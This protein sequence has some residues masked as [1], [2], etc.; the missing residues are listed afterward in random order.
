MAAQPKQGH[1][2]TPS[3]HPVINMSWSSQS[4]SLRC[5]YTTF[6]DTIAP[7]LSIVE[8]NPATEQISKKCQPQLSD[9]P[10]TPTAARFIPKPYTNDMFV[11]SG[12]KLRMFQIKGNDVI[13]MGPL[14]DPRY[15]L[16]SCGF[17]WSSVSSEIL[18]SWYLNNTY[19]VWNTES[20]KIVKSFNSPDGKQIFDL[21]YCPNDP[22]TVGIACEQGKLQLIDIRTN[23]SNI[24]YQTQPDLMRLSW[25]SCNPNN[26]ATFS[27]NGDRVIV[28]DMRK[29]GEPRTQLKITQNQVTCVDW[30]PANENELCIGTISS[31]V[32]IW[33]I[34]PSNQNE[35]SL[36]EFSSDG[37][38]N[39][40]CWNKTNYEWIG[41][42]MTS[43]VHYLHV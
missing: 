8:Y 36:L 28:M 21:K 6:T 1:L 10:F 23:G 5:L 22:N 17:D 32:M 4:E 34:R 19:C 14:E 33:V 15:P 39:D 26:I 43:T 18:C 37:E 7:H 31:K 13:Y 11:T 20:R 30:S 25:S 27:S 16:P 40:I 24:M 29:F 41:A 2:Q 12:D 42:A 35:N 3:P 38:V 9:L